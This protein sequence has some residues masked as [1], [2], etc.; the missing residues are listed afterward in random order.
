MSDSEQVVIKSVEAQLVAASLGV[1]PNDREGAPPVIGA[2]LNN[3]YQYLLSQ[4]AKNLGNVI[5][6]YHDIES[7]NHQSIPIEAI[8]PISNKIAATEKIWI[9]E[10]PKVDQIASLVYRGSIEN[11]LEIVEADKTLTQWIEQNNYQIIGSN[12]EVYLEYDKN[13]NPIAIELQYPIE[14]VKYKK[15]IF[16]WLSSFFKNKD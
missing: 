7:R 5:L 1:I 12:R 6:I 4:E 9:Y 3:T 11:I 16:S 10:L 14:K 8:I 15:N 2:L 13:R